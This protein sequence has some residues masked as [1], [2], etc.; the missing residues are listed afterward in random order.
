MTTLGL[1]AH[2]P[3]AFWGL[4][5]TRPVDSHVFRDAV[6]KLKEG[7]LLLGGDDELV[8]DALSRVDARGSL[9]D[10]TEV[11]GR[12]HDG[13]SGSPRLSH[14]GTQAERIGGGLDA[15]AAGS[16]LHRCGRTPREHS[17]DLFYVAPSPGQNEETVFDGRPRPSRLRRFA[18]MAAEIISALTKPSGL[19]ILFP[20]E[21]TWKWEL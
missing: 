5:L 15:K 14:E 8:R 17:R 10:H 13:S 2:T 12:V 9:E 6:E 1:V 21:N 7:V 3:D 16:L 4:G 19:K 18:A 11:L 20:I